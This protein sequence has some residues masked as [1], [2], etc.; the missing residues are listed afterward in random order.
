MH[1]E[2]LSMQEENRPLHR[3]ARESCDRV[4]SGGVSSGGGV[5]NTAVEVIL[6]V[7]EGEKQ[8]LQSQRRET[9]EKAA[10]RR[11]MFEDLETNHVFGFSRTDALHVP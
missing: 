2:N 9:T 1:R 3:V 5:S 6:G 4:P 11:R 8:V 7:L 10:T